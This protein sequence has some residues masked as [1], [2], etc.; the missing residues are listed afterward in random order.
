MHFHASKTA[1]PHFRAAVFS[2]LFGLTANSW[3]LL[4]DDEAR[5]AI[6]DLRSKVEVLNNRLEELDQRMQNIGKGQLDLINE[7][8]RLRAE[9]A[10]LRG[11]IEET[12]RKT[13]V[14]GSRQKDFYSDLDRRLKTIEPVTVDIGGETYQVSPAEKARFEE[15][16]SALQ[17]AEIKK[18]AA[19]FL[20]FEQQF[21]SSALAPLALLARG[22]AL[23]ADK[24]YKQTIKARELFVSKYPNHPKKPEALLNL[25]AAQAESGG[26]AAARNTLQSIMKDHPDTKAAAEAKDRLKDLPKPA[27][28]AKQEPAPKASNT[29]KPAASK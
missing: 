27:A 25:A 9:V 5:R 29:S 8:E 19:A 10:R 11:I 15:A 21:P 17:S 18:A 24:D 2:L 23:Y 7:N 20:K 26:L 13:S 16:Q 4:A 28:P 3:A 12:E 14:T 22:S 1:A 6:L